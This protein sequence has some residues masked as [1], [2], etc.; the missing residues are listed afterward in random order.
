MKETLYSKR[1]NLVIGFH[2]CDQLIV[3]KILNGED[4]LTV[5][6]NN[7]DWLGHGIYF[8]ENNETRALQYAKE[9]ALRKKNK[10]IKPA[11]IG[12]VIDLGYCM[13][14]TD[15]FFLEELKEAYNTMKEL[16]KLAEKNMPKNENVGS[17]TDKLLRKLDCAVIQTAHKINEGANN[18]PYDS[19][20]GVFWEGKSLYPDAGFSE[21]NH[22]Q[23]CVRNPNCIKGYFRPREINE[24]YNNP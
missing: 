5:S 7:Y 8:W 14:L 23:I 3:E 20:K 24:L 22:I 11:V 2:G 1:S 21:K 19:V 12:A 9:M 17:N 6:Q 4:E 16:F 13:D 18:P 15:S 10:N